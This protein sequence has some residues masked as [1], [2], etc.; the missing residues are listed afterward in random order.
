MTRCSFCGRKPSDWKDCAER[1][2]STP[3]DPCKMKGKG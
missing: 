1:V 2:H 3:S